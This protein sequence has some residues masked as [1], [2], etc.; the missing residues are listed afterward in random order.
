[1]SEDLDPGPHGPLASVLEVR[2]GPDDAH[3]WHEKRTA[4]SPKLNAACRG[5]P[6]ARTSSQSRMYSFKFASQWAAGGDSFP[7]S[8]PSGVGNA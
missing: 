3:T 6:S 7:P 4:E 8:K 5:S 1:M 2:R